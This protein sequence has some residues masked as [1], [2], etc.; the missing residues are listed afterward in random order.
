M[1][2]LRD[3]TPSKNFPYLTVAMIT[4]NLLIFFF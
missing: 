2:P 3:S 4:V 1:F